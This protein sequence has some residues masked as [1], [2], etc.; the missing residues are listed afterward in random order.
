MK[1]VR[2]RTTTGK[3]KCN[4]CWLLK[5]THMYTSRDVTSTDCGSIAGSHLKSR[6]PSIKES[7]SGWTVKLIVALLITVG[8]GSTCRCSYYWR[9]VFQ[10]QGSRQRDLGCRYSIGGPQ[11]SFGPLVPHVLYISCNKSKHFILGRLGKQ[12]ASFC[13]CYPPSI[14]SVLSLPL[15]PLSAPI[16]RLLH[17]FATVF[18]FFRLALSNK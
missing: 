6:Y 10:T 12:P 11:E 14:C 7:P 18:V 2:L 5:H 4:L 17:F 9:V 1:N 15:S 13:T 3:W 16:T 8:D